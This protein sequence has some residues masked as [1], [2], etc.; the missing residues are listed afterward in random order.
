MHQPCSQNVVVQLTVTDKSWLLPVFGAA[1]C[2][3][4]YFALNSVYDIIAEWKCLFSILGYN[5][6]SA[7]SLSGSRF[8]WN[9]TTANH[10]LKTTIKLNQQ[11]SATKAAHN[12]RHELRFYNWAL[13]L[14]SISFS[15]CRST[16]K[17]TIGCVYPQAFWFTTR[18]PGTIINKSITVIAR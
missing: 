2:V 15:Y 1:L 11:F 7:L 17:Q 10:N 13:V 8:N 6:H 3:S 16:N 9:N 18:R 5:K 12:N 4:C 14:D